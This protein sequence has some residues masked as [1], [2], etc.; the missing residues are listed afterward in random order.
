MTK[1]EILYIAN[2]RGKS[3]LDLIPEVYKE[4]ESRSCENCRY[5]YKVKE[6]LADN[7]IEFITKD[8]CC[9]YWEKKDVIL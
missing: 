7:T 9:N 3:C 4:L 1:E 5:S 2:R 8:L 6:C